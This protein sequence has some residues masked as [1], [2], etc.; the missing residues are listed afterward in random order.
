LRRRKTLGN[1][2]RLVRPSVAIRSDRADRT[3][4]QQASHPDAEPVRDSRA[5][6]GIC[7]IAGQQEEPQSH[8]IAAVGLL[9]TSAHDLDDVTVAVG[10]ARIGGVDLPARGVRCR[11]SPRKRAG[12]A[13]IS[14]RSIGAADRVAPRRASITMSARLVNH[15]S[16]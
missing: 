14:R 5:S 3:R 10:A 11:S 7:R 13:S 16:R 6:P 1:T 2:Y 8:S 12:C 4:C 15:L 9:F